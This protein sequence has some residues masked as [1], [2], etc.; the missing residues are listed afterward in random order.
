[1]SRRFSQSPFGDE[2]LVRQLPALL[3]QHRPELMLGETLYR[4]PAGF[5]SWSGHWAKAVAVELALE[6][7]E[8]IGDHVGIWGAMVCRWAREIG[9][10]PRFLSPALAQA[11]LQTEKPPLTPALPRDIACFR[12]LLPKGTLFSEEGP[13]IRSVVVADVRA[14]EGWLPDHFELAGGGLACVGL[15]ED[16]ATYLASSLLDPS[17]KA[18]Q[19]EHT[20][21]SP[22]IWDW[23]AAG[24]R[25]TTARMEQLC[26]HA[27]LVQL[28]VSELVS[29]GAIPPPTGAKGFGGRAASDGG[30]GEEGMRAPV[31]LGKEYQLQRQG[32]DSQRGHWRA[33]SPLAGSV[34]APLEWV[35]PVLG[36]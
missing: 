22:P 19:P 3:R 26:V 33:L 13:E 17:A 29:T 35:E 2:R 24:V 25:G 14:M 32:G 11:F 30:A 10:E 27:L 7:S 1:M 5:T 21:F 15:G 36:G 23:D 9:A 34:A 31:W 8:S 12:L 6:Q 20:D 18:Q 4:S 28:F 16:G